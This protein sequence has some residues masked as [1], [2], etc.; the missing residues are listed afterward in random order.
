MEYVTR[1]P[2]GDAIVFALAVLISAAAFAARR[3]EQR[4]LSPPAPLAAP[5][6][7]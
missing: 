4:R 1:L 7:A 3:L 5:S 6:A 2:A